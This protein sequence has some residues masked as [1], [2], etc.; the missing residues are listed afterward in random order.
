MAKNYTTLRRLIFLFAIISILGKLT[1]T[2]W[3][4]SV[5]YSV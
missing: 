1:L 2:D 3:G 4:G 5:T